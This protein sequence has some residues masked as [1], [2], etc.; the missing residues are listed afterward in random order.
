[1][2]PYSQGDKKMKRIRIWMKPVAAAIAVAALAG[3][4]QAQAVKLTSYQDL[5]NRVAQLEGEVETMRSS[6][7]PAPAADGMPGMMYGGAPG[8]PMAAG[9]CGYQCCDPCQVCD[10]GGAYVLFENVLVKPYFSQNTAF[11]IIDSPAQPFDENTESVDFDWDLE[12]SPRIE[13][14]YIGSSGMGWRARYWHFDHDTSLNASGALGDVVVDIVGDPDIEI[15]VDAAGTLQTRH[16]LEL[17]TVDLEA[18]MRRESCEGAV[19]GSVGLRYARIEH[20]YDAADFDAAGAL[21]DFIRSRNSFEGVGPTIA[22]E[23]RRRIGSGNL[24]GFINARGSLLFGDSDWSAFE[25]PT[26][27]NG[28]DRVTSDR[29]DLVAVAET[30]LGVDYRRPSSGGREWFG[31]VA[32]EAQ[33][34]HNGGTGAIQ[35]AGDIPTDSDPREADLGFVGLSIGLGVDW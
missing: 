30:Q 14:G 6:V 26:P 18:L 22:G 4:A 10:Q 33:Y 9:G 3:T 24:S 13:L 15:D 34:W 23:V 20:A 27:L 25:V 17:Y 31:R 12:Y 2:F 5:M 28:S 29:D 1:M 11:K 21:D 8:M 19:T 35:G 32:L 7:P 16:S